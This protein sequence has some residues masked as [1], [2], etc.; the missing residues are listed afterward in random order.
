[1]SFR[2]RSKS[3]KQREWQSRRWAAAMEGFRNKTV[4][5][6]TLTEIEQ[7]YS[8]AE[9]ASTASFIRSNGK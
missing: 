3:A 7:E 1:M 9:R 8:E 6:D 4:L 5:H 2:L